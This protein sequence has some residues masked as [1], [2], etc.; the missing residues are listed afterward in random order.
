INEAFVLFE[1]NG[2]TDRDI[3]R[4][5]AGL[6]TQ[7][8]NGISSVLGKSFQLARYNVFTGDP[9]FITQD[10]ENIKKVTK[11]EVIRV[12]NKYIKGKPYVMTSF[13]PKGQLDLIAQNSEKANV[14]EEEI[15][16]NIETEVEMAALE[17]VKTPSNFDRSNPPATGESPL[18]NIPDMWSETLKNGM[19]VSGIQND[20]IP[21]AT[22]SLIIEGGHLLDD[23]QKNGVANLMSDM[24]ME[25]TA[26][27]TPEELEEEIALLGA[28]INMYTTRE[29]IVIRGNTLTRNL[30]KTLALITEILLEPRWDE[31]E[32]VRVK[33]KTINDIERS[34][35]SPNAVANR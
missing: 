21:V 12:Y 16:E 30:E 31:A 33:T 14:V 27:K 15:K 18:L 26:N 19:K 17:I 24:L 3:E 22:F 7:F 4:I 9:G 35:A 28:N 29:S 11:E 34:D 25:G 20:E 1:K 2:V 13:V 10:I 8:Y 23:M 6:E 5:K 32:L